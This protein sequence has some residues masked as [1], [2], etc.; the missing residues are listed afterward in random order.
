VPHTDQRDAEVSNVVAPP[1]SRRPTIAH[2]LVPVALVLGLV[3]GA[4][5]VGLTW[6]ISDRTA[7]AAELPATDATLDAQ[8]ACADLARVSGTSAAQFAVPDA[9]YR[10]AGAAALAQ[11]AE[12]EDV[13]YKPLSDAMNK[14]ERLVALWVDASDSQQAGDALAAA[15]TACVNL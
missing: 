6:F 8:T 11:A 12:D 2:W 14:A 10:L 3:L 4:G 15:R 13:Y 9:F 5:A 7:S 1:L